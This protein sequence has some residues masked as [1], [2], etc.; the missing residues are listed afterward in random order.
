[1]AV[2]KLLGDH[3]ISN[4]PNGYIG[5]TL[6]CAAAVAKA[7]NVPRAAGLY[8]LIPVRSLAGFQAWMVAAP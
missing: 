6:L 3:C 1:M 8:T 4:G 2:Q 5:L 7:K